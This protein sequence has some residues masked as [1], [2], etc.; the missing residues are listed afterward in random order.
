MGLFG[1]SKKKAT[2]PVTPDSFGNQHL[3]G[4]AQSIGQDSANEVFKVNYKDKHAFADGTKGGYFKPDADMAPA[5]N[6]VAASRLAKGMGW[7]DLIPDTRYATHDVTTHLGEK[8]KNVTGAVSKAGVG[9]STM[10]P[11]FDTLMPNHTGESTDS[12]KVKADGNAYGL[13]GFEM[14]DL[15]M[16]NPTTQ[17]QL[18]QLQWFDALIG[19]QDRHGGNILIDPATGKVTGI[20]NDLSFGRGEKTTDYAGHD[21]SDKYK[22]GKTTKF[23][24]LP[25][26]LDQETADAL[27]ALDN[28]SVTALLRPDGDTGEA[29]SDKE[30]QQV[31]SRLALIKGEVQSK[32]DSDSLVQQWDDSTYQAALGEKSLATDIYGSTIH[33]SYV[34]RHAGAMAKANDGSNPDWWVKGR[35]TETTTPP[36]KWTSASTSSSGGAPKMNMGGSRSAAPTPAWAS[37]SGPRPSGTPKMA[38]GGARSKPTAPPAS[39]PPADKPIKKRLVGTPWEGM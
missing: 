38:M 4:K 10:S 37:A 9:E 7:G 18:N 13:S 1:K 16:S 25:S 32:V 12:T 34:Q 24:G 33:R 3:D 8:K 11:V 2:T 35:R 5:K 6:A 30:L 29:M 14:N 23:L 15:D 21:A 20:D 22:K 26:Q 28:D 19:N 27:L 39:K 31:Y 17:K 36:P